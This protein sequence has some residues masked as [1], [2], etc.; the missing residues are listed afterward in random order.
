MDGCALVST[1]GGWNLAIGAFPRATGRFES[2]RSADGCSEVSGQV[3]QDR[4]WL[5]YGLAHI[6]REPQRWLQ[7]IP[8]KW[9]FT[10]DHE[11]F[12]VEYLHEAQP[13]RWPDSS[14]AKAR[15]WLTT[16]HLALVVAASFS[17][18][19][20]PNRMAGDSASTPCPRRAR[21]RRRTLVTLAI[22]GILIVLCTIVVG[23]PSVWPVCIYGLAAYGIAYRQG[24][25]ARQESWA[26]SLSWGLVGTVLV[27]HAIFFGEDRYHMVISPVL[28]ILAASV[29]RRDV[30][31]VA[32]TACASRPV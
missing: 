10:L 25:D 2:L 5:A 1:N 31:P 8:K 21:W 29:F 14:R 18:F 27:T 11:S 32:S 12:P 19:V 17:A 20:H 4:C 16:F 13:E 7:L 9:A 28:C 26:L 6:R 30:A 15:A 22:A 3:Q 23:P 24:S